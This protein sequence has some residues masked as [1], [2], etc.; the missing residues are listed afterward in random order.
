MNDEV[1]IRENGIFISLSEDTIQDLEH[2]AEL[3]GMNL[4]ELMDSIISDAI[5][6][7]RENHPQVFERN[8]EVDDARLIYADGAGTVDADEIE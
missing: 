4:S 6:E 5:D 2:T 8:I 1:E 7:E 3:R